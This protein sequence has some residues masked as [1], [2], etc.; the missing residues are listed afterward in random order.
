M[1]YLKFL[2]LF[3]LALPSGTTHASWTQFQGNAGHTGVV[4]GAFNPLNTTF[5]WSLDAASLSPGAAFTPGLA[6]DDSQ[7]F[8]SWRSGNQTSNSVVSLD[9]MT[10]QKNW[11]WRFVG[12]DAE[13][14]SAP[15]YANGRL[16]VHRWGHSSSCGIGCHDKPRLFGINAQTGQQLFDQTHSGQWSSGGRPTADGDRV[17]VAG[18]YYGGLD[19]YNAVGGGI[20]WFANMPQRYGWIP[21]ADNQSVYTSFNGGLTVV[22]RNSGALT[23]SISNPNGPNYSSST[24]VVVDASEV[25]APTSRSI[26]RFDSTTETVTWNYTTTLPGSGN[27]GVAVHGNAIYANLSGVLHVI[28]RQTGALLWDW[29][30]GE[31]LTSNVIATDGHV[32]VAS[33]SRTY[34]VDQILREDVWFTPAGGSL[35]IVQDT[36]LVST[37]TSLNAFHLVPEPASMALLATGVVA[38]IRRRRR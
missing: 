37:T 3:I 12:K 22:N 35:A 38:G 25:Y 6:S 24:P 13:T 7:I 9:L 28:D 11:V 17:F 18:G 32:F 8:L 20:D 30:P 19:A 33:A 10:G 16:Y 31:A 26:T 1:T 23:G 15:A 27:L 29:S 14:M 5:A 36:L 34:A 21:A 4:P 2:V